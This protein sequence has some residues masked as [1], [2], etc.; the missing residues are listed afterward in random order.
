MVDLFYLLDPGTSTP[1]TLS[2]QGQKPGTVEIKKRDAMLILLTSEQRAIL[3]AAEIVKNKDSED[4]LR[5][6]G[7]A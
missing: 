6:L 3:N 7:A 5:L 2:S 4:H 1:E